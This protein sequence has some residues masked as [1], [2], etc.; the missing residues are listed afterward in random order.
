MAALSRDPV[1][2]GSSGLK[3]LRRRAPEGLERAL[4]ARSDKRLDKD[5]KRCSHICLLRDARQESSA[6]RSAAYG[7]VK[8][9]GSLRL[10]ECSQ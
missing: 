9:V 3:S 1:A 4:N 10:H 6:S 7:G 8:G 2:C 5:G